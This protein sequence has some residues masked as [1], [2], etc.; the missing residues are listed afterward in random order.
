[1]TPAQVMLDFLDTSTAYTLGQTLFLGQLPKGTA[2]NAVLIAAK[3]SGAVD[4]NPAYK[5]DEF[6][7]QFIVRGKTPGVAGAEYAE[8]HLA[9]ETVLELFLGRPNITVGST[10]YF[11]FNAVGGIN[12]LGYDDSFRPLF[13]LNFR[14]YRDNHGGGS[15]ATL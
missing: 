6:L 5:R 14:A 1:M 12:F 15:R 7:V 11:G 9:A 2:A 4:L 3:D 10:I 8:A 13:S